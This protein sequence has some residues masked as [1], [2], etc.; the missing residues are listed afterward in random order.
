M[1][2]MLTTVG[3]IRDVMGLGED[4]GVSNPVILEIIKIAQEKL[5]DDLFEHHYDETPNGHWNT[6]ATWNGVNVGFTVSYPLMDI[7]WDESVSGSDIVGYWFNSTN[8]PST[9]SVTVSNA[10]YGQINIYQSD[11]ST[12]IPS[13]A[14]DIKLEYYTTNRNINSQQLEDACTYLACHLIDICIKEPDNVTV[15]DIEGNS[16]E[17]LSRIDKRTSIY[18]NLYN[19]IIRSRAKP[20]FKST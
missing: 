19:E 8:V 18:K 15:A 3:K 20:K 12:A 6:G 11:G 17:I 9:C 7:N 10:R 5:K 4:T 2:V 16:K 1:R 14:E 13:T